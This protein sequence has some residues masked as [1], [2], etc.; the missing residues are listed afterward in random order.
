MTEDRLDPMEDLVG[1]LFVD[2]HDE[3]RMC[4]EWVERIPRWHLNSFAF[5]GRRRTGKTAILVKFFNELFHTQDR[6]IPVFISFARYLGRRERHKL[7]DAFRLRHMSRFEVEPRLLRQPNSVS[8]SQCLAWSSKA[9][10]GSHASNLTHQNLNAL[11]LPD[12]LDEVPEPRPPVLPD[13]DEIDELE[14]LTRLPIVLPCDLIDR[15]M[16]ILC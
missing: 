16:D 4:R 2:W 11:L 12:H 9:P 7:V 14:E 6:V 5:V 1:D 8:I 15:I 10:S 3:L 13:E